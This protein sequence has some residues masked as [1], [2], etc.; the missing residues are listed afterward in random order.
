MKFYGTGAAEGIPSPFCSCRVCENARKAGGREVR[1]RTMLRLDDAMTIDLGADSFQQALMY[2]DFTKLIHVLV[3]HTHEDHLAHMMMNVRNMAIRRGNEPLHFYFTD[4]AYDIVSFWR[5]SSPINKGL[6]MMM[7]EKGVVAFHKLNFYRPAVINGCEIVPLRG[8]HI[9]N[10]GEHSANYL[11]TLKDGRTLFY[12]LD[13]GWYLPET[14]QAL[15]QYQVDI[16]I[17][18]CTFG[19]T[20]NRSE[21]PQNH[22]DAFACMKLFGI[23]LSQGT[24]RKNSQIYL[25][26][27][28]HHT[29]THQEL[30]EWFCKQDF[31]CPITLTYDGYEID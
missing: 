14:I 25:T 30:S 26:H 8:N 11:I 7:E 28:N 18:E 19:L 17:S 20:P 29:S 1:R 27:I 2:G 31:P 16:M 22:L 12:G 9:G 5:A 15:S 3:T 24:L 21:H 13:T 4:K 23:L 10:M 6:T